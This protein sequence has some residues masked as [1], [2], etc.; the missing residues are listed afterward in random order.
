MSEP[1]CSQTQQWQY[2]YLEIFET[3][4]LRACKA[5]QAFQ[6]QWS[7][8]ALPER[9]RPSAWICKWSSFPLLYPKYLLATWNIQIL[10]FKWGASWFHCAHLL[11]KF[12]KLERSGRTGFRGDTFQIATLYPYIVCPSATHRT[13]KFLGFA[14]LLWSCMNLAVRTYARGISRYFCKLSWQVYQWY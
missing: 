8:F 5:K 1:G 11:S 10:H 4:P 12:R 7:P 9:G 2:I 3:F 13:E 14:M 6:L